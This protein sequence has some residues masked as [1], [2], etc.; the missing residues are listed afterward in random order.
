MSTKNSTM[1]GTRKLNKKENKPKKYRCIVKIGNNPD[2]SAKCV[3]YRSND[4]LK[5]TKFLDSKFPS[6]TWFNV[7]LRDN[8]KQVGSFTKFKKPIS[9]DV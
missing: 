8:G 7:Y 3:K 5:F 1:N 6:W 9:K 2:R 4:L